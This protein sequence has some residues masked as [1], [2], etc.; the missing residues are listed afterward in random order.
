[1]V[2]HDAAHIFSVLRVTPKS[3]MF[4]LHLTTHLAHGF[5]GPTIHV[6]A[7]SV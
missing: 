1:M 5:I 6:C 2:S 3:S 7:T 4:G